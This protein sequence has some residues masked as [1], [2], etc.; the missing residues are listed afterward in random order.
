MRKVFLLEMKCILDEITRC[1]PE[2]K[3]LVERKA[4]ERVSKEVTLYQPRGQ[5][6]ITE[7]RRYDFIYSTVYCQGDVEKR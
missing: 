4:D 3:N 6:L 2:W 5:N 7:G 1:R